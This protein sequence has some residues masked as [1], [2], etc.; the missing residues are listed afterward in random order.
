MIEPAKIVNSIIKARLGSI[1]LLL[2]SY[3]TDLADYAT[4]VVPR[5]GDEFEQLL[6]D[7]VVDIITQLRA[8]DTSSDESFRRY[9]FES[10]VRTLRAR[11]RRLLEAPAV[12]P[13]DNESYT[14]D[15]VLAELQIT[16]G[17]L[18]Q[19]VSE[20][21]LRA[22]RENNTTRFRP[23]DVKVHSK[24]ARMGLECIS[25]R[26][27]EVLALYFRFGFDSGLIAHWF[28][29]PQASVEELIESAAGALLSRGI[30]KESFA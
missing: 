16:E 8:A 2:R 30:I 20:G 23:Q 18:A 29:T 27:R 11:H 12:E 26:E 25:A 17:D 22:F 15:E 14:L 19:M 3:G 6:E 7:I 13:K 24:R 5:R 21:T 1:N 10:A 9:L 4:A 28:G